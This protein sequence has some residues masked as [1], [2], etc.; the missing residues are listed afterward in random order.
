MCQG[1]LRATLDVHN[2]THCQCYLLDKMLC[3]QIFLVLMLP[4]EDARCEKRVQRIK[5]FDYFGINS[6]L[7]AISDIFEQL[8]LAKRAFSRN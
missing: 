1:T 7:G 8:Q 5:P 4:V 3:L 2:C 6:V